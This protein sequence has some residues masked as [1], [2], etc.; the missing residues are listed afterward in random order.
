MNA[1]DESLAATVRAL[2]GAPDRRVGSDGWHRAR[3]WLEARLR[4]LALEPYRDARYALPYRAAE[5]EPAA[6]LG[7]PGDLDLVNLVGVAPGEDPDA[8]P[9]LVGAHYD[10]VP[11]SP[12]AD[13]NAAAIAVALEVVRRLVAR[14]A[15]RDV[16][17][18]LFAAEEP[19]FFHSAAM[20]STV[21]YE[22]Q[23]RGPVHAALILDLVGHAVPLPG[24]EDL[25]FVTGMESDPDLE[26]ALVALE[27]P[28]GVRIV[29]ALNRYVGD[30]S[31]HHAFRLGRTPY[32]FLTCGRWQHYHQ[33]SDTPEKLDYEK[34]AGVA[35]VLEALVRDLA[36][37]DLAGPWE[38]YDST[39]TE[40]A[41]LRRALGPHLR[42]F[43]S[44]LE[45]RADIDR[46][47]AML[48]SRFR[49]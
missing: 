45:S 41:F 47:A 37:R 11:G 43:G 39:P 4:E 24:A 19:P 35:G 31:D 38:G 3:A 14:P 22:R 28:E 20:G 33:P 36:T 26:R 6:L 40:L 10:T 9:L 30:M 5:L 25:V 46:V 48:M 44:T 21:F 42:A 18:A 23:R 34:M 27:P 29:P 7:V 49:I 13:D 17:V 12:G 2:T 16:L 8:A 1:S 32:L 15:G